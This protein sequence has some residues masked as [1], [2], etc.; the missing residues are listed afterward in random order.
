MRDR[1]NGT[2]YMICANRMSFY[3]MSAMNHKLRHLHGKLLVQGI[4]GM[5]SKQYTPTPAKLTTR[6]ARED[7][8]SRLAKLRASVILPLMSDT[9]NVKQN[10]QVR[11]FKACSFSI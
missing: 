5:V 10:I 9:S 8:P 7:F 6:T 1:D 2:N 4:L 11:G 3:R